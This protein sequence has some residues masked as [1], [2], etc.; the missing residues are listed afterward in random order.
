MSIQARTGFLTQTSVRFMEEVLYFLTG[1]SS[2]LGRLLRR[3]GDGAGR[4]D[5]DRHAVLQG[6]GAADD[7][8]LSALEPGQDLDP[9]VG[10]PHAQRQ[11]ALD[12][13][14]VFDDKGDE[15]ALARPDGGD[16]DDRGLPWPRPRAR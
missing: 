8:G 14:V 5:P 10:R 7:Q 12:G 3:G 4:A 9:P 15:A 16:R 6:F 2:G 11:D 1:G 13:L